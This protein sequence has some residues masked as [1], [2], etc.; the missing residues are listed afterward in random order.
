MNQSL[1]Q[2]FVILLCFP[3]SKRFPELRQRL[4]HLSPPLK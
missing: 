1:V 4:W 3:G 2:I